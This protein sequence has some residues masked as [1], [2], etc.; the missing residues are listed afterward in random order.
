MQ[1]IYICQKKVRKFI[2]F[3]RLHYVIVTQMLG[4]TV[5]KNAHCKWFI[6]GRTY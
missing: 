1:I 2:H 4:K 3:K 5:L 6:A